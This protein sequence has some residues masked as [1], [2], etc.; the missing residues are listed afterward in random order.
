MARPERLL[1]HPLP[2]AA[3][4]PASDVHIHDSTSV[5]VMSVRTSSQLPR[6]SRHWLIGAVHEWQP[7]QPQA[8]RQAAMIIPGLEDAC[9]HASV[10]VVLSNMIFNLRVDHLCCICGRYSEARSSSRK[11]DRTA[12]AVD[13][14]KRWGS[15]I[16]SADGSFPLL[17]TAPPS[18]LPPHPALAQPPASSLAHLHLQC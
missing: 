5:D 1:F 4:V 3:L 6:E 2:P 8:T 7:T 9:A 18:F 15:L 17:L 12:S 10:P 13:A 14:R 16:C 11:T